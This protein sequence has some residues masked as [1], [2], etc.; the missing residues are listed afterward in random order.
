[1]SDLDAQRCRDDFGVGRVDVVDN[2]VD[3]A[4]FRPWD[5]IREPGTM[6]FLGSLEWRPNL[7]GVVQF[8]ERVLPR[9]RREEPDARLL[10]VGRNPPEWLR[11]LAADTPGVELHGNVP[12]VRPFLARAG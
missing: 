7:D 10:L 4:Y 9:I 5:G 1:V 11:R 2:G 8:V 3:T 12:D 6:L